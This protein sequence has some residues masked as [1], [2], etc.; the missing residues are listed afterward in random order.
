[1]AVHF[2]RSAFTL[3]MRRSSLTRPSQEIPTG[4]VMAS[5]THREREVAVTSGSNGRLDVLSRSAVSDRAWH[6]RLAS[7]RS[8]LLRRSGHRRV[9]KYL[10]TAARQA[11]RALVA[12]DRSMSC[13]FQ[14]GQCFETP[15]HP[16]PF[17]QGRGD[18]LRRDRL[19]LL[20]T[21][22]CSTPG[23]KLLIFLPS[24]PDQLR[25]EEPPYNRGA[26]CEVSAFAGALP[27]QPFRYRTVLAVSR[28][29]RSF[30]WSR[31]LLRSR[32]SLATG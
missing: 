26:W 20:G 29:W 19:A 17:P 13:S 31:P 8:S 30:G 28:P 6:G 22:S 4:P 9:A 11:D 25:R 18:W 10:P 15:P 16:A 3:F 21:N 23:Q 32:H 12:P 24:R 5:A 7:P 27:K 14:H 1:M 2:S